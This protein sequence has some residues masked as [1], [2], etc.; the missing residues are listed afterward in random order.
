MGEGLITF[1]SRDVHLEFPPSVDL[2]RRDVNA[3]DFSVGVKQKSTNVS[4]GRKRNRRRQTRI[5]PSPTE[6]FFA[7]NDLSP[8]T[9][10]WDIKTG[11][12]VCGMF[13]LLSQRSERLFASASI[14]AGHREILID[15]HNKGT[16]LSTGNVQND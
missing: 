12:R 15:A 14:L 4:R 5:S 13:V 8:P 1:S 7:A 16:D 9:I 11:R 10:L 3:T 2:K 6:V